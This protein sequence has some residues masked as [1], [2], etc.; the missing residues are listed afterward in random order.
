MLGVCALLVTAESNGDRLPWLEA[1]VAVTQGLQEGLRWLHRTWLEDVLEEVPRL[2]HHYPN[3]VWVLSSGTPCLSSTPANPS[4]GG[5]HAQGSRLMFNHHKLE[6]I[7]CA[8]VGSN[9]MVTIDE[10]THTRTKEM[11]GWVVA[12]KGPPYPRAWLAV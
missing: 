5:P 3:T 8:T 1:Q 12:V 9:N 7:P 4:G 11:E 10:F 2:A 6:A